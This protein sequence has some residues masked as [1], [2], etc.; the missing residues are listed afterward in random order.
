MRLTRRWRRRLS[1]IAAVAVVGPL[2]LILGLTVV[3]RIVQP[4]ITPLQV[5]RLVQ[6]YGFERDLE[7]LDAISPHL[8]RAVI[9]A[10]DNRFCEHGGIDWPAFREQWA[11]WQ[12]GERPRGASTISMQT[13]KNLFLW[14]GRDPVR[15]GLELLIT[16]AVDALM[17]KRRILALYLNQVELAP[18]VY[19]AEAAARHHFAKSA[20]ELGPGEAARLAVLLPAP[21]SYTVNERH[22]RRR[23][24]RIQRRVL[25]LGPLL[26][27]APALRG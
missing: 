15:K 17:P 18:G 6:G 14:P 9:A 2:L 7:P 27:C 3:Y 16:P 26:D 20:S 11:R 19:G 24:E 13:T 21:L 10:E 25:Q 22:V 23:A 5:I 4:P 1:R 8:A 12:D